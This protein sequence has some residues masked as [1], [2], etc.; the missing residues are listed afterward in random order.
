MLYSLDHYTKCV[1]NIQQTTPFFDK[2]VVEVD[3]MQYWHFDDN[4]MTYHSTY[5]K[6]TPC[7][8]HFPGSNVKGYRDM[9]ANVLGDWYTDV[10]PKQWIKIKDIM[11]QAWG[12]ELLYL[13]P[14][15][16]RNWK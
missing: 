9:V 8:L 7:I 2:G 11:K 5:T 3:E 13:I 4:T 1:G 14:S 10:E 12:V 6:Q 16:V 15:S